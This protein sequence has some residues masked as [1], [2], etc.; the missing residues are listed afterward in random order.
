M[1]ATSDCRAIAA[2]CLAAV[3][4][5]SSLSQQLPLWEVKVAERDRPLLRQLCYGVLRLHPLLMGYTEQL[6]RKPFKSKDTDILMLILLGIYQLSETRIPDHAAVSATVGAI[7]G[8]KKNWAKNLVNG[9]L[10]QWQRNREELSLK[11]SP[12]QNSAHPEWF[13]QVVTQAWPEQADSIFTANNTHPPMCLRVNTRHHDRAHYQQLLQQA[14]IEA[15]TCAYAPEGLRLKQATSVDKLPGFFEGFVSV[16]DEAPQLSIE[17][18]NLKPGQRVLDTCCA[19]GGKT[20]HI[21]EA[22]PDLSTVIGLDIDQ[23]RLE[24]VEENFERLN[25]RAQ[26]LCADACAV[27]QWW[28]KTPFDRILLDAPCS[29]TGVIRRNPDI[30]LHRRPEDIKQLAVLQLQLLNALWPTLKPGGLLLYATCSILPDENER[31]VEQFCQQQNDAHHQLIDAEWGIARPFGRQLFPQQNSH[32]GFY[33][34]LI[35]KK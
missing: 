15:D 17:L 18:L 6:L 5:G 7:R 33:Y 16:Q 28:D 23:H 3:A 4:G 11:L 29:A 25:L 21:L 13:Y 19:P 14:D 31:V 8:L 1:S 2:R 26:L 32:D 9:V 27:D 12:A 10:R 22:E 35:E 34:A 20:C 30:K 24:R